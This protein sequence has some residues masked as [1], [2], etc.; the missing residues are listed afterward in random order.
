MSIPAVVAGSIFTFSLTLGDYIVPGLVS[1]TQYIGNVIVINVAQDL[2]FAAAYSLVPAG[3]HRRLPVRRP[4]PRRIRGVLMP[5][6]RLGRRRA[7]ARHRPA[8]SCSSMSR[9]RWSSSTRSTRAGRRPGRRPASPCNGSPR[10]SRTPG[11]QQAFLT[12]IV[13]R[14]GS[15]RRRDGARGARLARGGPLF[16]LRARDGLVRPDPGH[17]PAGRRHRAWR[18]RRRSAWLD[19]PLGFLTIVIGHATFCIVL[20]YNNAIAR[21]RRTSSSFEEASADLGADTFQTFRLR[22]LPGAPLGAD[23][24]RPAG[25]RPVVRRGHRHD[26]HGRRR[27]RRCRSG[28]SRASGW[29]TRSRS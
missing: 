25:L 7:P 19:L 23:R 3:D 2:P 8:S 1:T 22:D 29:P 28:S 4:A 5:S 9:S 27:R 13:L 20:V 18:C 16:V 6:G 17:R 21:L 14:P 12:S 24:R 11:L 10:R 15:D 26:L